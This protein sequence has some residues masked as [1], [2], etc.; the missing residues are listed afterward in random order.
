MFFYDC[1]TWIVHNRP[2][3][4]GNYERVHCGNGVEYPVSLV[5]NVLLH[6]SLHTCVQ[7][8]KVIY[9]FYMFICI[10]NTNQ[11]HRGLPSY[12]GSRSKRQA[13]P[14]QH[15]PSNPSASSISTILHDGSQI[16]AHPFDLYPKES[17]WARPE[18]VWQK[19]IGISGIGCPRLGHVATARW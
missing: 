17:S 7:T 10:S 16:E 13:M 9:F 1:I 6:L 11:N 12:P 18:I 8:R 5:K 14:A 19:A 4:Y 2:I 3:A 15:T